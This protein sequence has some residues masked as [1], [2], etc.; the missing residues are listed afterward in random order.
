[1]VQWLPEWREGSAIEQQLS[2]LQ[3]LLPMDSPPR[4]SQPLESLP[5]LLPVE[6]PPLMVPLESLSQSLWLLLLTPLLLRG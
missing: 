4:L 2:H 3:L 5:R 6:V 1:M